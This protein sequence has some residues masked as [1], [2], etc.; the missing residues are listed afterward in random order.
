MT[1]TA[2][3]SDLKPAPTRHPFS[4]A[5]A[6]IGPLP[7]LLLLM[8][9]VFAIANP[10][11]LSSANLI[12][13][14]TQSVFLL[15]VA[16]G[17]MLV[18]VTGGFD[19]SV[20]ANVAL[21]SIVSASVMVAVYGDIDEYS[22]DAMW[23]GFFTAI[24]VGLVV[25]LVNGAGVAFLK[26]NAFIVTLA[27][28]SVFTGI[29]LVISAGSEINGLPRAFT[30][31]IGSGD[32]AGVPIL[33][34]LT[35]PVVL[36]LFV[37]LRWTRYGRHLY[38]IGGN[39]TAAKV[40]GVRVKLNL[41]ATYVICGV[42]TSY[43]GW[44]LTARVAS[45]QPMLGGTFALE[46]ITAAI[47]GGAALAGGRGGVGGTLLGVIFIMALTNGMNLMR[48]DSN[49]QSIAVGIVLVFAV[50]AD[51]LRARARSK[52]AETKGADK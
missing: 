18:L 45:G 27:S 16:L 48:L 51:R 47:I 8:I 17:Q 44:L 26:V 14:A 24:V 52:A 10:V 38:A 11:F 46:S 13:L 20:G 5:F 42:V 2:P 35:L 9:I 15:L 7:P 4:K 30:H 36:V 31:E 39:P 43:A 6:L 19:L 29:T 23:A 12:T 50:V 37:V 33:V 1:V 28:T 25:G 32:V 3:E 34:L 41:L 22:G 49:Q 21:T 40:A